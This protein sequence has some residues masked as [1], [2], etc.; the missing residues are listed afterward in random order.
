[1]ARRQTEDPACRRKL[2]L[3][4]QRQI[5]QVEGLEDSMGSNY[6]A[7]IEQRKIY[8][9]HPIQRDGVLFVA[10]LLEIPIRWSAH[11]LVYFTVGSR[12][13]CSKR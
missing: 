1:M 2:P 3:V 6:E 5:G 9:R 10:T 7:N 13:K 4:D 12:A 11:L 8:S